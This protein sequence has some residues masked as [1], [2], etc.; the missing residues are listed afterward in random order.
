MIRPR[1]PIAVKLPP[2]PRGLPRRLRGW[3]LLAAAVVS[4]AA[5]LLAPVCPLQD[6]AGRPV[7][8]VQTVH[9]GDTVTC[10]DEKGAPQ[11]IRLLGIDAPEYDQPAGPAARTALAAK[12]GAAVRVEDRGRDQHGR[13]LGTLWDG[14][15]N[16]NLEMVAE[17]WAWSFGGY[18]ED[19]EFTAAEAAAR[20]TRRGLW[21]GPQPVSPSQW[22]AA[23]PPHR[24]RR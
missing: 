9:D 7:W 16:L 6:A 18:S 24:D 13:L 12:A 4:A 23:H 8:R 11:K 5:T 17:G 3:Y 2:P 1:S 14:E 20:R 10:L 21:A 15:R 22:R 19:D